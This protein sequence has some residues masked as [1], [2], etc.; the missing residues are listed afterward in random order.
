M[1]DDYLARGC[2]RLIGLPIYKFVLQVLSFKK[3]K[4]KDNSASF[5]FEKVTK[6]V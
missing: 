3:K 1:R 6:K 2:Q 5:F 4:Q